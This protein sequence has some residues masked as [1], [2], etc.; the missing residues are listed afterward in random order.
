MSRKLRSTD[1]EGEDLS[2]VESEDTVID[3]LSMMSGDSTASSVLVTMSQ[4]QGRMEERYKAEREMERER[5]REER[6]ARVKENELRRMELD[7][8]RLDFERRREADANPMHAAFKEG[9]E[10][11]TFLGS[12]EDHMKIFMVAPQY[13]VASLAPLLTDH[14]RKVYQ[15]MEEETRRYLRE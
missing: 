11:D 9:D 14:L 5:A 2:N 3:G 12:F 13:W 1:K 8:Q 7:L 10:V 15:S 4:M 6:E